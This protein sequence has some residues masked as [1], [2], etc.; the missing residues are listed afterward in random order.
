MPASRIALLATGGTIGSFA[1]NRLDLTE[2]GE[3]GHGRSLDGRELLALAPEVERVAQVHHEPCRRM[4]STAVT[5]DDWLEILAKLHRHLVEEGCCQGAVVTHGTN[6]LEETAYFLHLTLKSDR[7][8]TVVGSMRPAS[9]ISSDAPLNLLNAF[10]VAADPAAAGLGVLAVNNDQVH[11]ARDVTKT[12]TY[13]VETFQSRDLG[14]LGYA[15]ADGRVCLYRR[16]QRR[17]TLSSAFDVRGVGR[18]PRVDIAASYAGADGTVIRALAEAGAAGIVTA[19][20]GAGQV[21]PPEMEALAEAQARGI[22]VVRSSRVGS[23][24][25]IATPTLRGQG[26]VAA[27]NLPPQKARVLLMLALTQTREVAPIQQLFDEH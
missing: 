23:G 18:L 25:V 1:D 12:A 21:S 17:H 16:P 22:V 4:R 27:D 11:S 7:P 8:V 9:G 13:R 15:D 20:T 6:T 19:G 5:P 24:R 26:S 10:R 2:Y 3:P 14:C